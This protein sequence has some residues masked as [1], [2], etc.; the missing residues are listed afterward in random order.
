MAHSVYLRVHTALSAFQPQARVPEALDLVV[1]ADDP[2][3][4]DDDR[5]ISSAAPRA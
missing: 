5:A 3:V 1:L 4:V 2:V